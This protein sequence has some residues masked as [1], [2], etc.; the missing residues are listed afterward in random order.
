MKALLLGLGLQGK[1]VAHDLERSLSIH[2]IIAADLEAEKTRDYLSRH[3]YKKVRV[4]SLD[5]S[6]EEEMR[7]LVRESGAQIAIS[8]L[9]ITFGY[10]AARAA[11]DAGIPYVSSNYTGQ[12]AEL[13]HEALEKGITILPEMGMD[14]GDD[15]LLGRMAIS[16]LDEVRGFYSYGGGLPEPSCADNPIRYKITWTFDGVLKSYVRPALILRDG[17]EISISG[18]DIFKEK[19]VHSVEVPEIGKMEAYPN[20]DAVKYMD[21]FGLG[22]KVKH[23]GRFGLRW[24]GHCQFWRVMVDLAFLEETPE[25]LDGISISP[26]RFLVRHLEPRLQFQEKERDLVIIQVQAWGLK[27]GKEKTI[28]YRLL[29]YRDLATGLFAMNRTVGY[30]A[31]I[32][33]QMIL[34]GKIRK[35]GVLSPARD[36]PVREV[37]REL[38]ARGMKISRQV[39]EGNK[40]V[41]KNDG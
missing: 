5:A 32:G 27:D 2:E 15:L 25:N 28:T 24:P 19:Y 6:Q 22:K 8:M 26:R 1:A 35:P 14:P 39:E 17:K 33:A 31:S 38:E 34:S 18:T 3:D 12:V 16:E 13:Q 40:L 10:R 11:L 4:V 29:D 36:V 41:L 9:P 7:R 20:G 23:M 30:T 21:I 37:L